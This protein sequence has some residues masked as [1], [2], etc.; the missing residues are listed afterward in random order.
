MAIIFVFVALVFV[1]APT[2]ITTSIVM[3]GYSKS[4]HL[5][6]NDVLQRNSTYLLIATVNAA[7]E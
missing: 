7:D 1:I 5:N 3:S 6:Y 2:T 4:W